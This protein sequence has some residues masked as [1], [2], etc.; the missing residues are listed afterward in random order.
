LRG[1]PRELVDAQAKALV[2]ALVGAVTGVRLPFPLLSDQD[3]R[4]A[5]ALRLPIFRAA[6]QHRLKRL[7]LIVDP[8]RRVRAVQFPIKDPAASVDE[9][10]REVQEL[11]HP[12]A[13]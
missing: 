6:G 8:D 13:A 4:L 12:P 11:R 10:L 7:T 3:S 9:A 2:T 1:L 5:G